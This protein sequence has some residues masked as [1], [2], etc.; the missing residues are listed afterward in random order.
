MA[1][2]VIISFSTNDQD[3]CIH[4]YTSCKKLDSIMISVC[5]CRYKLDHEGNQLHKQNTQ[6]SHQY[7]TV[8]N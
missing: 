7:I 3:T 2:S 1:V 5:T 8:A 6:V 4:F